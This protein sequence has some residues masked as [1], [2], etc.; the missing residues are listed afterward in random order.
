MATVILGVTISLDGYAED[1]TGS[2]GPL[3]PDLGIYD[4]TEVMQETIRN[5]GAVVIAW[6]E[7]ANGRRAGLV[8]R[9]L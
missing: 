9:Q 7:Y 2:V 6:K 5:T 3:Y 8:C 1:R 4:A